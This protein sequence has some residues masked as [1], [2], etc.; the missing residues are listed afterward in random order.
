MKYFVIT[1]V[2]LIGLAF[3]VKYWS[4][5]FPSSATTSGP[6]DGTPCA[7][8]GYVGGNNGTYKNGVCVAT[9]NE[10][11]ACVTSDNKNGVIVSGVCQEI[12]PKQEETATKF[13]Q[14]KITNPNGART[15]AIQNGTFVSPKDANL[16][17]KD[18]VITVTEF[19]ASPH[20]Y[21]NTTSGWIDGDDAVVIP[22]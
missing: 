9:P 2:V 20:T 17:P 21:Y 22:L 5:I 7:T 1:I 19:V 3:L 6:T 11:S 12:A 4:K 16:I 14:V 8:S 18:T 13:S 10:G 15:L